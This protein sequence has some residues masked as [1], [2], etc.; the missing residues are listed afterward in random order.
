MSNKIA[1]IFPGQGSQ[2]S[3]MCAEL[4]AAYNEVREV[5]NEAQSVLGYDLAK[6]CFEAPNDTLTQTINAQ[7]AIY[8]MSAACHRLL[9]SREIGGRNR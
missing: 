9:C 6:M 2:Y 4:Y 8:T 3:G 1:F 5:F 7:P